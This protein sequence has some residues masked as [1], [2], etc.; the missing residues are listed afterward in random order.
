MTDEEEF[1]ARAQLKWTPDGD[2]GYCY[3]ADA[4]WGV[5]YLI[6]TPRHVAI[7]QSRRHPK[8]HDQPVLVQR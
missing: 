1:A 4:E 8:R 3:I 2:A 7:S 5:S 6:R